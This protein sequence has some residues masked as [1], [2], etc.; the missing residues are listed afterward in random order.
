MKRAKP[1]QPIT[2]HVLEMSHDKDVVDENS[3]VLG[4]HFN[5]SISRDFTLNSTS[6]PASRRT[7]VF[8]QDSPVDR[9]F[10]KSKSL[11][12]IGSCLAGTENVD[13]AIYG[14]IGTQ[15]RKS[16]RM[17]LS[18][19]KATEEDEEESPESSFQ[20]CL[21]VRGCMK[22]LIKSMMDSWQWN[23]LLF[24]AVMFAVYGGNIFLLTADATYYNALHI[25]YIVLF[26]LFCVEMSLSAYAIPKYVCSYF[27]WLDLLG[28]ASL[29]PEVI[30]VLD[31]GGVAKLAKAAAKSTRISRAIRGVKILR[32]MQA[33]KTLIY[34][35]V[36]VK[37]HENGKCK[38]K[39]E[40]GQMVSTMLRKRIFTGL[41]F[42]LIVLP[43]FELESLSWIN[44]SRL[45][46]LDLAEEVAG[47]GD[48]ELQKSVHMLKEQ[49]NMLALN[50]WSKTVN[51]TVYTFEADSKYIWVQ[52][53][54]KITSTSTMSYMML[55]DT[56]LGKK[57]ALIDILY[58]SFVFFIF[59]VTSSQVHRQTELVVTQ[60]VEKMVKA[61][62]QLTHLVYNLAD[63][64]L[65]DSSDEIY[66]SAETLGIPSQIM[67]DKNVKNKKLAKVM[68][69]QEEK[70]KSVFSKFFS[71]SKSSERHSNSVSLSCSIENSVEQDVGR[72]ASQFLIQ[73]VIE[74]SPHL[75]VRKK[76]KKKR[77][78]SFSVQQSARRLFKRSVSHDSDSHEPI[79]PAECKLDLNELIQKCPPLRSLET[80]LNDNHCASA[81]KMFLL[82]EWSVE[83]LLFL[84]H[85]KTYKKKTKGSLRLANKLKQNFIESESESCINIR[86]DQRKDVIQR[87]EKLE[88]YEAEFVFDSCYK[89]VFKI[90]EQ[91]TFPRFRRSELAR[92][93]V[94]RYIDRERRGSS[95]LVL[96]RVLTKTDLKRKKIMD[97]L[98]PIKDDGN[99]HHVLH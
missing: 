45:H 85:V 36:G 30:S 39:N 59:F 67:N 6:A 54:N 75:S 79:V 93:A 25:V 27:F 68:E 58:I 4:S 46:G 11:S 3:P 50:L 64:E 23:L 84:Q 38:N 5:R 52:H 71:S 87:L 9:G 26:L 15:V 29:L 48:V 40:M 33:F 22:Q 61:I 12:N 88:D 57:E 41:L 49:Y 69:E 78:M 32:M 2:K 74:Q 53:Q 92:K 96:N 77:R 97:L 98:E 19:R 65:E 18:F 16:A 76:G 7:S 89:E 35:E 83:N 43:F 1:L 82:S 66:E 31:V 91:G 81:L 8:L 47:M 24:L 42:I 86:D 28:T 14:T 51:E 90:I 94:D 55:D 60:P 63:N 10:S 34:I 99:M 13:A 17:S 62:R 80:C 70:K 95:S 20:A 73:D 44:A 56:V 72:I 21:P 37:R